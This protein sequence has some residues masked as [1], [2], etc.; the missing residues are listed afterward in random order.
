MLTYPN[1]IA[2]VAAWGPPDRLAVASGLTPDT[3]HAVLHRGAPRRP[4]HPWSHLLAVLYA[5]PRGPVPSPGGA[6]GDPHVLPPSRYVTDPAVL[7][8]ID[9]RP[10]A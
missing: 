2:A 10:A 7:R 8:A 5:D 4:V 9:G 1:L 6:G 3:I